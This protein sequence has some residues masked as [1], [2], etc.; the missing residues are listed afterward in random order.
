[1][2][3]AGPLATA[4]PEV[5]PTAPH[6]VLTVEPGRRWEIHS[7]VHYDASNAERGREEGSFEPSDI[8]ELW[9]NVGK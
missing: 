6:E 2:P 9:A 1:M 8:P 4:E 7:A 5:K 3:P